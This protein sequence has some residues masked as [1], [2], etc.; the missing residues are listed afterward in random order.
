[1][2]VSNLWAT[3]PRP[4]ILVVGALLTVLAAVAFDLFA[5]EAPLHAATLGLITALAA[6]LRVRLAG[7]RRSLVEFV[8]G[9][10]VSQ[11]VIH[12]AAKLVPHP[13][14]EHGVGHVPGAAD[15]FVAGL[16]IM[17]ILAVV[18]ALT[19]C[20]QLLLA[21]AVRAARLCVVRIRSIRPLPEW[22]RFVVT[23]APAT[24]LLV[25]RYHPGSIPRRGPPALA[26]AL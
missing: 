25:G 9:C 8:C 3:P 23:V 13:T 22:A 6:A 16:Q 11:P 19:F 26:T 14:V 1:M 7:R 12:Y 4:G 5:G 2:S 18:A 10:I 21:L 24:E 15:L 20:E 17:V